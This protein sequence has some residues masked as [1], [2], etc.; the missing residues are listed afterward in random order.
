MGHLFWNC[1]DCRSVKESRRLESHLFQFKHLCFSSIFLLPSPWSS[2]CF[3][4]SEG[5]MSG[6]HNWSSATENQGVTSCFFCWMS[7]VVTY[8]AAKGVHTFQ[9]LNFESTKN[10]F[11]PKRAFRQV[12]A[13]SR[14]AQLVSFA[15]SGTF[16]PFA[17]LSSFSIGL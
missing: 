4:V 9:V 2:F 15:T 13:I 1:T 5:T 8:V 6:S 14:Q 17:S 10:F 3:Q 7:T 11:S 12:F 16:P